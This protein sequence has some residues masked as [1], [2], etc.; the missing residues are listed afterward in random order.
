MVARG[1]GWWGDRQSSGCGSGRATRVT[2]LVMRELEGG[3]GYKP[4]C[5][6]KLDRTK[7][8]HAH[9]QMDTYK[10]RESK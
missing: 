5:V 1:P 10:T 7:Y 9:T 2:L 3:V 8:T 6:I 4:T